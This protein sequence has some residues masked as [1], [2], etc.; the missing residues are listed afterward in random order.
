M[1][2]IPRC[3]V[4]PLLFSLTHLRL[5]NS[6]RRFRKSEVRQKRA[7]TLGLVLDVAASGNWWAIPF[8]LCDPEVLTGGLRVTQRPSY[9]GFIRS[10]QTAAW[11]INLSL[12][13]VPMA[14]QHGGRDD[15]VAS[16]L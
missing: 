10:L 8:P 4:P 7:A 6:A 9:W 14:E 11:R 12:F 13:T 16:R 3:S 2:V 15:V 1:Y 5:F